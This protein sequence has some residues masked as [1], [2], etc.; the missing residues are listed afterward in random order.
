MTKKELFDI[1]D[2]VLDGKGTI[3]EEEMLVNFL[4]SFQQDELT[5]NE[6][7]WGSKKDFEAGMAGRIKQAVAQQQREV[8]VPKMPGRVRK[9]Y[10]VRRWWVAASILFAMLVGA[11]WWTSYNSKLA[12]P[13]VAGNSLP[14]VPGSNGAVLTLADGSKV[15]LDSIQQAVVA[16]QGGATASVVNGELVY[17]GTGNEVVYNTMT[18]PK[19]RQFNMTLADGTRVWLNAASSIRYPTVFSGKERR[20]EVSGEAYFEVAKNAAMPFKVQVKD[21]AE[22]EVLGTHF[23]LNAYENEA[24][25]N[26][27]LLE[28][29]VKVNGTIIR[30]GQQAQVM[31]NS[32][33]TKVVQ[34]A[35]I[36]QVM[37]WK[38]GIFRFQDADLKQVMKQLERWYDI[39]VK[40]EGAIPDIHLQGKMDRGV[41]L[42]DVMR[43]LADYNIAT[44]LE[45]RTL[46]ISKNR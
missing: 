17:E 13:A 32:P 1:I 45:N 41:A 14:V 42:E 9:G 25:I 44:R 4:G 40:Y 38:N 15:L 22:V 8:S 19:G 31:A 26:T 20:V 10:F 35:D 11:Y 46:I 37:A 2:R 21:V 27:T 5:W 36:E 29:S 16:L 28:G 7:E 39:E 18:T 23:N 6:P 43:F 24:S 34:R 3:R 12:A 33:E 30:P